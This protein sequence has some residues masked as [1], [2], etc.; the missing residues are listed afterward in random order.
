MNFGILAFL[1]F[2]VNGVYTLFIKKKIITYSKKGDI[3][4]KEK[5]QRFMIGRYGV[6]ELN[7]V[8]SIVSILVMVLGL[9]TA[10]LLSTLGL[11]LFIYYY[12]RTFSKNIYARSGENAAF[13]RVRHRITR[14]FLNKKLRLSQQKTHRFYKCSSCKKTVRVPRG[15]GNIEI[16]CP[17]CRNQFVK[18]S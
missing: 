16:T 3:T 4:M 9:F 13:L 7:R 2:L 10:P 11:A 5:L 8:L 18:K 15:K 6:D 12:F 17:V 1:H 14:W